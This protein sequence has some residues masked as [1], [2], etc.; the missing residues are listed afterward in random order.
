M[1]KIDK[2]PEIQEDKIDASKDY[3]NI[4]PMESMSVQETSDFIS[5]EL[6][7]AHDEAEINTYD[8]LLSE[9]YNR[10]EEEINIE[11]KVGEPILDVLD[12]FEADNWSAFDTKEQLETIKD[13]VKNIGKELDIKHIP[14]I[15]LA[16]DGDFYGYYDPDANKIV[17]NGK[18]LDD[19]SG[20][21]NTIAHETR[22][23]YQHMRAENITT[24]EDALY[25]VNFD[26]YISPITLS[27]GSYLFFKDYY[28][29]YVEVDARAFANLFSEAIR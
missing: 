26:N 20:V 28:D 10:S 23:A 16:P 6:K 22:H 5:T 3:L 19:P 14:E 7:K 12:K 8:T 29:Q 13:L 11:F 24:W 27:D 17:I 9:V 18:Y 2:I 15:E 1:I 21:V 4:K 25:K